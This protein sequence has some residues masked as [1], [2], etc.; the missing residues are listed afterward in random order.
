MR[1]MWF[2]HLPDVG[3]WK[4]WERVFILPSKA[5]HKYQPMEELSL[6]G[7]GAQLKEKKKKYV[8]HKFP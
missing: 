3:K 1:V 8:L 7:I 4:C 2:C 5:N 6:Y